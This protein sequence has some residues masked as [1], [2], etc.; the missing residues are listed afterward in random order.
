M[1][2]VESVTTETYSYVYGGGK[3]LRETVETVTEEDGEIATETVTR[4]IP[5]SIYRAISPIP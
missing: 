5:T 1:T 4:S 2:V 3:L